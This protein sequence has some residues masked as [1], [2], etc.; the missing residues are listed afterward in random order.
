MPSLLLTS[1]ITEART[2]CDLAG[3]EKLATATQGGRRRRAKDDAA[4]AILAVAAGY[5]HWHA[6]PKGVGVAVGGAR[7][8]ISG[9]QAASYFNR[10]R[11]KP[12]TPRSTQNG[13]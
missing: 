3:K 10:K 12:A 9:Q 2:V 7:S 8:R 13:T 11:A 5:R 6:K 4:A 1:A